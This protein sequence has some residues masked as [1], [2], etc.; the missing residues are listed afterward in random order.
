MHDLFPVLLPLIEGIYLGRLLNG[1]Q[2]VHLAVGG[3]EDDDI[4]TVSSDNYFP[5]ADSDND[6]TCDRQFHWDSCREVQWE[7]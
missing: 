1:F 3:E 5:L 4:R 2:T 7:R 6:E